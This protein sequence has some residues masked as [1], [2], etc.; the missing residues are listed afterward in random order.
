MVLTPEHLGAY[1]TITFDATSEVAVLIF[2]GTQWQIVY[3]NATAA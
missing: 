2:V 3:T 1:T